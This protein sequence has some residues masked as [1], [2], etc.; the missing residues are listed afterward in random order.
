MING[1]FQPHFLFQILLLSKKNLCYKR[2]I[3][4]LGLR[5][6]RN[7]RTN[8]SVCP[9]RKPRATKRS[10]LRREKNSINWK[11]LSHQP[12]FYKRKGTTVSRYLVFQKGGTFG[13]TFGER[14]LKTSAKNGLLADRFPGRTFRNISRIWWLEH[15]DTVEQKKKGSVP[16]PFKSCMVPQVPWWSHKSHD[17]SL[18]AG[19][20]TFPGTLPRMWTPSYSASQDGYQN[21]SFIVLKGMEHG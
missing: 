13:K 4:G 18:I 16:F 14:D 1:V 21:Q 19:I 9:P 11:A 5:I 15:F 20:A 17:G 2:K 10:P 7:P 12:Y 6:L 3:G 8:G